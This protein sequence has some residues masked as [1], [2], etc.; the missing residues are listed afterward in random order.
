MPLEIN[1]EE[2]NRLFNS[3]MNKPVP[4]I[5]RSNLYVELFINDIFEENKFLYR[6]IFDDNYNFLKSQNTNKSSHTCIGDL[7]MSD[8]DHYYAISLKS[9]ILHFDNPETISGIVNF[10]YINGNWDLIQ[11][12]I[13]KV[14]SDWSVFIINPILMRYCEGSVGLFITP[15]YGNNGNLSEFNDLVKSKTGYELF[16]EYVNNGKVN[17]IIFEKPNLSIENFVRDMK[18]H[19]KNKGLC[20][21]LDFWIENDCVHVDSLDY[22][23]MDYKNNLPYFVWYDIN[24]LL[25]K[26][27]EPFELVHEE[28][29]DVLGPFNKFGLDESFKLAETNNGVLNLSDNQI[30]DLIE[31]KYDFK[32][33]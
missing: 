10:P 21:L 18:K 26:S 14:P 8:F 31:G 15:T 11:E 27:Y 25:I 12:F 5:L 13:N 32:L 20:K 30:N 6:I 9:G 3:K 19:G 33:I 23:F 17:E 4:W 22:S 24:F 2:Y 1:H 29:G 28:N 16:L 7:E